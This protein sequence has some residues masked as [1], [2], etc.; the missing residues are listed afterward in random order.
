MNTDISTT[1]GLHWICI[2][3]LENKQL[4]FFYSLGNDPFIYNYYIS[5]FV[6]KEA[7]AMTLTYSNKRIQDYFSTTCGQFCVMYSFLRCHGYSLCDFYN[8]FTDDL[9]NNESVLNSFFSRFI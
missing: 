1:K 2:F 5:D 3:V 9:K 4:E 8:L 7:M 6:S